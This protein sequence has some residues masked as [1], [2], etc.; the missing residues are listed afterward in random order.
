MFYM[1]SGKKRKAFSSCKFLTTTACNYK[2][3][4]LLI[5]TAE[6]GMWEFW[7]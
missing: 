4:F 6:T 1:L 5:L 7:R 2:F 3:G